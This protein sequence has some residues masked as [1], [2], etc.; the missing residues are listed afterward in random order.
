[1]TINPY[2]LCPCGSGKK[3]KFCCGDLAGEMEKVLRM[4]EGSQPAAAVRHLEQ[5]LKKHPQR[6][7]LLDLKSNIEMQLGWLDQASA[8]VDEYL[9]VD[10]QSI[11]AWARRAMQLGIAE[12][13]QDAVDA[14][15]KS[16]AL[17]DDP[18]YAPVVLMAIRLLGR[19]FE[20]QGQFIPAIAHFLLYGDVSQ[21][22]DMEGEKELIRLT[23]EELVPDLLK[24][25][26]KL[27]R[28]A[29]NPA[30]HDQFAR[31][32]AAA[33]RGSWREAAATFESL[34]VNSPGD[35]RVI[36]NAALLHG[37]LGEEQ[38]MAEG[39]RAYAAC[40]VSEE[41]AVEALAL[42]QYVDSA[43]S[44]DF[45][46][47]KQLVFEID[48]LQA[49]VEQRRKDR[50][51]PRF[52]RPD[53]TWSADENGPPPQAGFYVLDRDDPPDWSD[54]PFENVPRLFASVELFGRETDRPPRAVVRTTEDTEYEAKL[55]V[56]RDLFTLGDRD[57]IEQSDSVRVTALGN[58]V[59]YYS[60]IPAQAP[61]SVRL[62][63]LEESRLKAL[64]DIWPATP[65]SALGGKS[66]SELVGD[67]SRARDLQ[68]AVYRAIL[69]QVPR[70]LRE[71]VRGIWDRLELAPLPD[72]L[73]PEQMEDERLWFVRVARLDATKLSDEQIAKITLDAALANATSAI[74]HLAPELL[75]RPQLHRT[76][77]MYAVGAAAVAEAPD[78]ESAFEFL[79]DA[80]RLVA[81][82]V[83]PPG[84]WDVM[85]F[86]GAFDLL[87]QDRL[88][89]LLRQAAEN[90]NRNEVVAKALVHV[91][92]ERGLITEDGML[93]IPMPKSKDAASPLDAGDERQ[94]EPKIWT[95]QSE[96]AQQGKGK[97]WLPS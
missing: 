89:A 72:S 12:Q 24:G 58:F 42:A 77:N 13:V 81:A 15:Q 61:I 2:A 52:D 39:L 21:P 26:F 85:E 90:A 6:A 88:P 96:A 14:L 69:T 8:T 49:I 84:L 45:L 40:D 53:D 97:I 46:D 9:R 11:N 95:P 29:T 65:Q 41:D 76:V 93:R 25:P 48:D 71:Q 22:G 57:P 79:S 10:P 1:M 70:G 27:Y 51:T 78:Y 50:R 56:V 86:A 3:I 18:P 33:G 23:R 34:K 68:A 31:A 43:H 35:A 94:E 73:G 82:D 59:M 28:E 60:Y 75:R 62:R 87:E 83:V 67:A 32:S 37:F 19:T 66:P 64:L 7:S 63:V 92:A 44:D 5:L 30:Q 36:Y 91:L 54:L 47:A 20:A 55:A 16:I 17:C 80:R 74:A 4:V 38:S